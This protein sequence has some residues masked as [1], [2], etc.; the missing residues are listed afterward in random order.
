MSKITID[1][2]SIE[3]Q[4]GWTILETARFLGLEI[5]T[6]CYNEGLTPWGGCRLCVVEIGEGNN[7]K[8]VT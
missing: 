7:A 3:P 2:I 5:P 4:K 8:L 1:G 6:L